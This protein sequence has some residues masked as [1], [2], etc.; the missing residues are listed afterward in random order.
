MQGPPV[1]KLKVLHLTF[2][3]GCGREI[4]IVSNTISFELTTWFI[5]DLPGCSFDGATQGSS[6]YNIG[7]ERSERIWNLH[8]E[9]FNSFDVVLTSDTAPL[10]RI[11]LQN[12]WEKPLIIWIC[13][14]FDYSDEASLDCDFPDKEYYELFK[15]ACSQ[16]NVKIIGYTAY[17]HEYARS[18]GINTGNLVIKPAGQ[19]INS[20]EGSLVPPEII[21]SET[22]FLPPYHNE[23]IFMDAMSHYARMGIKSYCGRYNGAKDLEQF[24]AIIHLPYA[25][26]NL[27]LFE[28]MYVGIPYL[29]PSVNFMKKLIHTDNYW[30]QSDSK[31][32]HLSEWYASENAP[33]FIY[34]DSWEDLVFKTKT[35]DFESRRAQIKALGLKHA[36]EM[37]RR[38]KEVFQAY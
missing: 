18:K 10:A 19:F 28:N 32:F 20:E 16:K 3:R 31:E 14:R 27:A 11:F 23:T 4:E 22:F 5:Q 24:K 35:V 36:E 33:C 34:F 21:K 2:H 12:G 1:K 7:H 25:W 8:Q 37:L 26:S 17:E 9:F 38:W 6:L 15:K 30:H 29:I 13:N